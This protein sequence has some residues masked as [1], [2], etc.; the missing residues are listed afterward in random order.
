MSYDTAMDF[1]DAQ[2]GRA[3]E[4]NATCSDCSAPYSRADGDPTT[5]CD[6]CSDRRDGW[7][8]AVEQRMARATPPT[9]FDRLPTLSA[10]QQSR[11]GKPLPK[12]ASS[13][14]RVA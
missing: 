4:P 10:V 6:A 13:K 14:R 8:T 9:V 5:W 11:A 12:K 1:L 2:D 3:L 7:V